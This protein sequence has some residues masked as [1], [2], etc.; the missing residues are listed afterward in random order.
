MNL[1]QPERHHITA[2]VEEAEQLELHIAIAFHR[3][4]TRRD[5]PPDEAFVE[6]IQVAQLGVKSVRFLLLQILEESGQ[7]G[8]TY[9]LSTGHW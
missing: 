7:E 9:E 4:N 6:K 1:S 3:Q 5:R 8:A 2:L